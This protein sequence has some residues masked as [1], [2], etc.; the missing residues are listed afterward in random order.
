MPSLCF[1]KP[2]VSEKRLVIGVG[3]LEVSKDPGAVLTI[4]SL[5]SC[6]GVAI[7]DPVVRAGGLL[8]AM[9]PDSSINPARAGE[10]PAMFVDTGLAALFRAAYQLGA[11]KHRLRICVAGASHFMDDSGFFNIG[12]RN[13]QQFTDILRHHGLAIA[14]QEVGGFVS[15]TM[16]LRIGAGAVC[17]KTSGQN[18][19]TILYRS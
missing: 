18:S 3:A 7:Y 13:F 6:L 16:Q 2:P 4:F 1:K 10:R 8:H 14:A 15:R 11:E 5:G 9:L 19:E 12:Q 17:L